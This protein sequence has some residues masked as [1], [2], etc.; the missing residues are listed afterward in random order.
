[1]YAGYLGEPL[2]AEVGARGSGG[3]TFFGAPPDSVIPDFIV[4]LVI[5]VTGWLHALNRPLLEK[6]SER[7]KS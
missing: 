5:I 7:G 1:M 3:W 6:Q 2:E 4:D